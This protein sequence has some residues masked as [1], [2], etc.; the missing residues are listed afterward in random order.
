MCL[1]FI[2]KKIVGENE[3]QTGEKE[4]GRIVDEDPEVLQ[5]PIFPADRLSPEARLENVAVGRSS[6]SFPIRAPSQFQ[7]E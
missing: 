7:Q 5:R 4:G 3:R 1:T 6:G 2:F